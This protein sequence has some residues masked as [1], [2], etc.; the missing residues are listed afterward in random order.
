MIALVRVAAVGVYMRSQ[1]ASAAADGR[2]RGCRRSFSDGIRLITRAELA[3]RRDIVCS[4]SVAD[5]E[6][7][8][9][10]AVSPQSRE[11]SHSVTATRTRLP[12]WKATTVVTAASMIA[13]LVCWFAL[14][15]VA[16]PGGCVAL[17]FLILAGMT[18]I[19]LAAWACLT[20]IV[21]VGTV[22]SYRGSRLGPYLTAFPNL[23]V[24]VLF[25][26]WNPVP[27][28][29]L[30]WGWLLVSLGLLPVL[31][32]L[33]ASAQLVLRGVSPHLAASFA[34]LLVVGL[35]IPTMGLGWVL[36]LS[37]AYRTPPAPVV[38]HTAC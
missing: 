16:P 29:Q 7:L 22:L 25:S 18:V 6:W 11:G 4:Q 2:W 17:G 5:H 37:A 12:L 32:V 33:L 19:F 21:G 8:A 9:A 10:P 34:M 27:D 35:L 13:A 23:F 28:G 36:D 14:F 24:I 3:Y 31:A 26:W 1:P 38:T 15:V 20:F 30:V